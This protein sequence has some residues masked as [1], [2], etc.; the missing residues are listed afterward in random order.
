MCAAPNSTQTPS[1]S[2]KPVSINSNQQRNKHS[3]DGKRNFTPK[4]SGSAQ[5]PNDQSRSAKRARWAK[6]S[7]PVAKPVV[8]TG[9]VFEYISACCS[10]PASKPRC[11]AKTPT[12]DPETGRMKDQTKGLGH[13]RCSGCRKVCKVTPQKPQSK[14][15]TTVVPP[16]RV[17][18]VGVTGNFGGLHLDP[19]PGPLTTPILKESANVEVQTNVG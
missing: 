18:E 6:R 5:R 10:L 1:T 7:K 17:M 12:K 13:F 16:P 9:P 11:G 2:T 3:H 8:R 19:Y 15:L 4:Q 14:V